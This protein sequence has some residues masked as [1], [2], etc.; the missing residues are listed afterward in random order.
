[1]ADVASIWNFQRVRITRCD[2]V[3]GM[4]SNILVGDRLFDFRHMTGDALAARATRLVMGT[5]LNCRRVRPGLRIWAMAVEAQRIAGLAHHGDVVPAMRIVT[6]EAGDAAGIHQTVD[7]VVSLHAVLVPGPVREMGEGGLA[8]LVL[9][10]LPVIRQ[11]LADIEAHRPI[12]ILSRDRILQWLALGVAL[13]A[14]VVGVNVV[15]AG[16]IKNVI[17]RRF[18]C[19]R[20]ARA[21]TFFATDVPLGD[22]LRVDVVVHGMTAV[23]ERS[24]G[25]LEIVGR[26]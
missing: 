1:M 2:E 10:E 26:I 3:K 16:R 23:A 13:D 21:V 24:R 12:V 6:T 25:P 11:P 8:E 9:F 14:G 4:T 18:P 19:M 20:L 22:G 17:A 5:R 7:E 15:E